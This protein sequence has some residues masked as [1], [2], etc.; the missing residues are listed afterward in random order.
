MVT[1]C[2]PATPTCQHDPSSNAVPISCPPNTTLHD[3]KPNCCTSH[4][5]SRDSSLLSSD[6]VTTVG[7]CRL[8]V[9]YW[10]GLERCLRIL[11]CNVFYVSS[12][13]QVGIYRF[14]RKMFYLGIYGEEGCC[15]GCMLSYFL[16][17][18]GV[19]HYPGPS[20]SANPSLNVLASNLPSLLASTQTLSP[21]Q[22]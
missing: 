19:G 13:F 2:H 17:Y 3:Q 7:E 20:H 21:T 4:R 16:V 14:H 6:V 8:G 10:R 18:R 9:E 15:I 22:N 12:R 1:Q 11:E 5:K